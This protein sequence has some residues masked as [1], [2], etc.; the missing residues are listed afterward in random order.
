MV[1]LIVKKGFYFLWLYML[2]YEFLVGI[3]IFKHVVYGFMCLCL[4]LSNV[5]HQCIMLRLRVA[6]CCVPF[7]FYVFLLNVANYL[8]S[9]GPTN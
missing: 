8:A 1:V 6:F 5:F 2:L 4:R 7:L 9:L 3:W